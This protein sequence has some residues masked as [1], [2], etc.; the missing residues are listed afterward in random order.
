MDRSIRQGYQPAPNIS[1][2]VRASFRS[3]VVGIPKRMEFISIRTL[4]RHVTLWIEMWNRQV[5]FAI[6][7][8]LPLMAQSGADVVVDGH[9]LWTLKTG[10]EGFSIKERA[11]EIRSNLIHVA[12][13]TRRSL[14][15]VR[16]LVSETEHILLVGWIY[17]FSSHR[18]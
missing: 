13:D 17:L 2:P 11:E 7:I 4:G 10:R 16:E 9:H 15:D 3:C 18:R 8:L 6:L 5:L 1:Y 12:E 14:N